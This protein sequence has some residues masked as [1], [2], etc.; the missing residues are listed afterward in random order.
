MVS[1]VLLQVAEESDTTALLTASSVVK[2]MKSTTGA[3]RNVHTVTQVEART[4]IVSPT[5]TP[6]VNG[7]TK[8]SPTSLSVPSAP[9]TVPPKAVVPVV[10]LTRLVHPLAPPVMF[11]LTTPCAKN[12]GQLKVYGLPHPAAFPIPTGAPLF[13][14]MR[15]LVPPLGA[16]PVG[17]PAL[18]ATLAATVTH[19]TAPSVN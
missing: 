11:P 4:S 17:T 5:P 12:T 3:G 16:I 13:P 6:L 2:K 15:L 9:I 19:R 1:G 10:R 18:A 14:L 7:V 8:T